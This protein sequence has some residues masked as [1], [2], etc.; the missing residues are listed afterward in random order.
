MRR[1]LWFTIPALIVGA[2]ILAAVG[3]G[4][5]RSKMLD[6]VAVAR[7]FFTGYQ[8]GSDRH[9]LRHGEPLQTISDDYLTSKADCDWRLYPPPPPGG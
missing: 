1:V 9:R 2:L 7:D 5:A 8:A 4:I 3:V 6:P